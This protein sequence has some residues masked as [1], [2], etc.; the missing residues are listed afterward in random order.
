VW[1]AGLERRAP[2]GATLL[3]ALLSLPI[4]GCESNAPPVGDTQEHAGAGQ[5]DAASKPVSKDA[6]VQTSKIDRSGLSNVGTDP[7]LDY[8]DP[9]LWLCRPGN[10]PDECEADLDA[11]EL[12]AD[13]GR[14]VVKHE[15]AKTPEFDCFY[16]Y[17][18]VKLTSG[19][20]MT[21]FSKIDITLDPLLSQGAR[22]NEICRLYAPLYRQLGVVPGAG[23][24][25]MVSGATSFNLGLEDVRDAFKYYLEHFNN[26][27]KFVLLGHSQGTGMLT[28]MMQ[29]D[30]DPDEKL[31]EQLVSALLIGGGVAVPDDADVGG[32]FAN[33]PLCKEA[34]QV[35]C[36]IAYNSFSK[37]TPPSMGTTFARAPKDGQHNAC[38]EPALLAGR[39]GQRYQGSYVRLARV[40]ATLAPDGVDKLPTDIETPFVL[41]RD[42]FRGECKNENG[43]SWLEVSLELPADDTRPPP[44]YHSQ[45]I[46]GALGLHLMDY[47]LELDDLIEAVRLQGAQAL[48]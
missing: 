15:I 8:G 4:A 43:F 28:A 26:G 31:R 33:I 46:E 12:L 45:L 7:G 37:E 5:S 21:D 11:T 24:A 17:P 29:M 30:L 1:T 18:T 16:V 32:T 6:G 3:W 25:P 9:R 48:K 23:G 19:G 27:R 13:G 36:V 14:K 39:E 20:P 2:Y 34:G 22:F 44:P 47:N 35:G 42:V 41:Y 40:N 10:S 38:T